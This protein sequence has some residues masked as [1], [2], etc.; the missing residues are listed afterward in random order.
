MPLSDP[1]LA[2]D[3]RIRAITAEVLARDEYAKY[4]SLSA[5][6]LR[7]FFEW[8][9]DAL[10]WLPGLHTT[11]P[12]L[13]WSVMALLALVNALLITHIVWSVRSA[14]RRSA[15]Q[16]LAEGPRKSP[17]F[18]AQAEQ[19]ASR[20]AYLEAAHRL[21]LAALA[22]AARARVLE[23][24]PD[25]GNRTVC[26][27]LRASSLPPALTQQLIEL[28]G[29]TEASWFGARENGPELYAAWLDLYGRLQRGRP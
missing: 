6:S 25:D 10:D 7:K 15:V 20:G 9:R 18:L 14:L 1:Q 21:L 19:L 27:K 23:L 22:H 24:R 29:R 12:L 4:R 13:F 26:R 16:E 8:V 28:I 17:D 11:S 2:G 5:E 3:D